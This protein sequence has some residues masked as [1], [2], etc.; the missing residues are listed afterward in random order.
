VT[1]RTIPFN[2]EAEGDLIGAML[3]SGDAVKAALDIVEAEDFYVPT[4]SSLFAAMRK[5]HGTGQP[6]DLQTVG[7]AAKMSGEAR[8]TMLGYMSS[9]P[10]VRNVGEYARIVTR[11]AAARRVLMVC[12]EAT[13]AAMELNDPYE[14]ADRLS[15]E[16]GMIDSPA[17]TSKQRARTVEEIV[18]TADDMS[19][20][21]IDGMIRRDWRALIV[22]SEGQGKSVILR[23]IAM[24]AA[25]GLHPFKFQTI[26]KI[27]T[28]VV[29]L[30]NPAAS[31]AE[32]GGRMA[33]RLL[34]DIPDYDPTRCRIF[35]R[36]GGMDPRTR[37][38]KTELEREITLQRPDLVCIGPIYKMVH[39]RSQRG[40]TESHEEATSPLLAVL[41]DLRTRYGFGLLI[42]SH[43][44]NGYAGQRDLR[45]YGSQQWQAWPEIGIS[46]RPD[47]T[48]INNWKLERFRGDRMVTD[49]PVALSH[50]DVWPWVGAWKKKVTPAPSPQGDF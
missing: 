49:W 18:A 22:A 3:L 44:P 9:V 30:E 1:I 20:W 10:S 50:G 47:K 48:S 27:R 42:E 16:L 14:V 45:P 41:D 19:P 36:P 4:N 38:G 6:V 8:S 28:L 33:Q 23:Q 15:A 24:L 7:D 21:I 46:L 43:A 32:T 40:G 34:R 37:H 17:D 11:H 39:R 25:N 26:P 31:I 12:A 29:D 13:A 2:A 35:E 5:L